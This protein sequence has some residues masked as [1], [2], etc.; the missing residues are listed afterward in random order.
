MC[1]DDEKG[2]CTVMKGLGDPCRQS[3][4]LRECM[5][6]RTVWSVHAASVDLA[7][8]PLR[9]IKFYGAHENGSETC[10]IL[11]PWWWSKGQEAP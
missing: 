7:C 8:N 2:K 3:G 11:P 6:R 10:R 9:D 5:G 1:N 4:K